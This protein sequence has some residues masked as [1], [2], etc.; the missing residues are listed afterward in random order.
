MPPEFTPYAADLTHRP[1]RSRN[2]G[3]ETIGWRERASVQNAIK[4]TLP[5]SNK[6]MRLKI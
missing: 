3:L 1:L 4:S 5:G 2:A 6:Q